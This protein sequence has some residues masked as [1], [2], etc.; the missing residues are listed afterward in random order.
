MAEPVAP[1]APS[2]LPR[3]ARRALVFAILLLL[4]IGTLFSWLFV[5]LRED[6]QAHN[7]REEAIDTAASALQTSLRIAG[8]ALRGVPAIVRPDGTVDLAAFQA[9]GADVL[10]A[11]T[12]SGMAYEAVVPGPDRAAFEAATGLT[13]KDQGPDGQLVPAPARDRY[14]PIVSVVVGPQGARGSEGFDVCSSAPRRAAADAAAATGDVALSAPFAGVPSGRPSVSLF[15]ALYPPGTAAGQADPIGFVSLGTRTDTLL[16]NAGLD[17]RKGVRWR[18]TDGD[19]L[20]FGPAA[21]LDAPR[22]TIRI[23]GREWMV[24]LTEDIHPSY[25]GS[26]TVLASGL[27]LVALLSLLAV[28]TLRYESR[29]EELTAAQERDVERT[30]KVARLARLLNEARGAAN[31]EA[32]VRRQA[33]LPFEASEVAL[34]VE[35]ADDESAGQVP[36]RSSPRGPLADARRTGQP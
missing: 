5:R 17:T 12:G 22:H 29:L 31:V 28:R 18:V 16:A 34:D 8:S 26:W 19:A 4:F 2:R 32:V 9:Y 11:N 27:V 3:P 13:I 20:V 7:Q 24:Q 6:D 25:A 1:A 15:R 14:C 21:P 10:D 23:G 33:G 30:A 35:D 36:N